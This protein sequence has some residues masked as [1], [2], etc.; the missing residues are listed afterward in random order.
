[1]WLPVVVESLLH[2][3]GNLNEVGRFFVS[4][5]SGE[6][7][8]GLAG[9]GP[10]RDRIPRAAPVVGRSRRNRPREP[11][12]G[13]VE[14][15]LAP[16]PAFAV[17]LAAVVAWKHDDR[18]AK[19]TVLMVGTVTIA[20]LLTLSRIT[21]TPFVYLFPWRATV[22]AFTILMSAWVIVTARQWLRGPRT[23]CGVVRP[24]VRARRSPVDRHCDHGGRPPACRDGLRAGHRAVRRR[25]H[26]GGRAAPPRAPRFA[27]SALGGVHAGIVDELDDAAPR[28]PSIRVSRTPSDVDRTAGSD[29]VDEVWYV[30]EDGH[31]LSL[32]TQRP[33]RR[34]SFALL[35][36]TPPTRTRSSTC[37]GGWLASSRP[38]ETR[39]GSRCSARPGC[40]KSWGTCPIS[41]RPTYA[42]STSS[43]SS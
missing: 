1:M 13:V 41:T 19:R 16:V 8:V 14:L 35:L 26:R 12:R 31:T 29:D 42:D 15:A 5:G 36:S 34:C 39:A 4:G 32:L 17:A 30:V 27:G 25:A 9:R 33:A 43:T 37:N 7:S 10:A 11:G 2:P 3:P 38:R 24:T 18:D 21:G 23:T 20:A 22:G 6:S 40:R 28:C